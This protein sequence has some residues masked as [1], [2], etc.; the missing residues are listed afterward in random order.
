ME[1]GLLETSNYGRY[2]L[3]DCMPQNLLRFSL[4]NPLLENME[5]TDQEY[6]SVFRLTSGEF[7]L[8]IEGSEEFVGNQVERLKSE[9]TSMMETDNALQSN[10]VS[11]T[12]N[13]SDPD[14][15]EE[16]KQE[17][18][19]N[20][21]EPSDS[22]TFSGI[23]GIEELSVDDF[24]NVFNY[25]E[26]EQQIDLVCELPGGNKAEQV[27]SA[28]LLALFGYELVGQKKISAKELRRICKVRG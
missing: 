2:Q 13:Q 17:S 25:D 6:T 1:F 3:S 14:F 21:P 19:Q 7:K 20:G 11:F 22:E 4:I 12:E 9:I 16:V 28:T 26:E 18:N 23:D 27:R 8:E 24:A 5:S 10:D 15:S